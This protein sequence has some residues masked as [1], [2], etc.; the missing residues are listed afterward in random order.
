VL[1]LTFFSGAFLLA[2]VFFGAASVFFVVDGL[3][4][5]FAGLEVAVG[6]LTVLVEDALAPR[7]FEDGALRPVED[8]VAVVDLP[9]EVFD[10]DA[11]FVADFEVVLVVGG[12]EVFE[13]G[14]F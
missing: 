5:G 9:V 8:L 4:A 7:V 6:F 13:V 2:Y 12:F 3:A 11:G 1:D 10:F 14:L